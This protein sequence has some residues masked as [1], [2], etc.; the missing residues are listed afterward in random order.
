MDKQIKITNNHLN[1]LH[2]NL[3][4]VENTVVN[5]QTLLDRKFGEETNTM[6][7]AVENKLKKNK[8]EI[9]NVLKET[10]NRINDS[11][12]NYDEQ[13]KKLNLNSVIMKYI[14]NK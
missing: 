8:K 11:F 3:K 6:K 1:A 7:T 12:K 5:L 9:Q 4:D 2:S 14:Y 10:E 13:L